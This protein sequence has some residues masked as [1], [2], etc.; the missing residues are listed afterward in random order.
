ML[1]SWRIS[2]DILGLGFHPKEEKKLGFVINLRGI[3]IALY[4]VALVREED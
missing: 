3:K 2:R 4:L 1:G